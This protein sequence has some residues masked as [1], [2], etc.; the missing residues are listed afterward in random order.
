MDA[1]GLSRAVRQIRMI[2]LDLD[3]TTMN[4]QHTVTPHTR[5]VLEQLLERGYLVVPASGRGYRNVREDILPG[6]AFSYM[7]AANGSF[8][9]ECSTDTVLYEEL[10]P[11]RTAARLVMDFLDDDEN[12]LY[13]HYNDEKGTHRKACRSE[14]A[15]RRYYTRP[16]DAPQPRYT[17]EQLRDLILAAGKGIPKIGLWFQRPDGFALYET[18]A[19]RDYPEVSAYRVSENSLEFCSAATSKGV[20]LRRLCRLLGLTAGQVCA[21]GDNG[22]DLD[23]LNFAGLGVAVENAIEPVRQ[24]AD[25]IAGC[26]DR[27]GAAAFLERAFLSENQM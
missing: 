12:C 19:A 6:L 3:G 24:A 7:I 16:W 11:C 9:V 5:A 27:E 15:Y 4:D 1:Q 18:R 26:N 22:N 13:V 23:M 21:L 20:A 17:A 8:V 25:V 2:V 14:E 10:I